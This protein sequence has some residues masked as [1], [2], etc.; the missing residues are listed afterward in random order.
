MIIR[1]WGIYNHIFYWFI[2]TLQCNLS[3]QAN[4]LHCI[5]HLKFATHRSL[6]VPLERNIVSATDVLMKFSRITYR[7]VSFRCTSNLTRCYRPTAAKTRCFNDVKNAWK[8]KFHKRQKL[9]ASLFAPIVSLYTGKHF[10]CV[11]DLFPEPGQFLSTDSGAHI[12]SYWVNSR[13]YTRPIS[14]HVAG[15]CK[16]LNCL[17]K[18]DWGIKERGSWHVDVPN[19]ESGPDV[20]LHWSKVL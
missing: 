2:V 1:W 15:Q 5:G 4:K 12:T 13:A 6:T 16:L 20:C 9:S 3:S 17:C 7:N 18:D 8:Y 14:R 11:F 10:N 19:L